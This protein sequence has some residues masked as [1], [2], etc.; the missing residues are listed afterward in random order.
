MRELNVSK[1]S[2]DFAWMETNT[3]LVYYSGHGLAIGRRN[4]LVQVDAVAMPAGKDAHHLMPSVR[5]QHS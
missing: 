1:N 3:A 2:F 4:W 5:R